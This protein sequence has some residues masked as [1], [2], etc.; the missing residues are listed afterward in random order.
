[1]SAQRVEIAPVDEGVCSLPAQSGRTAHTSA[2][3]GLNARIAAAALIIVAQ[4]VVLSGV[5]DRGVGARV[6]PWVIPVQVAGFAIALVLS[7]VPVRRAG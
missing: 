3:T 2:T 5:L 4:L 1:M 6:Q 7:L